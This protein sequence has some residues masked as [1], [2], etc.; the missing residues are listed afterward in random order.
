MDLNA[1]PLNRALFA[2][3]GL[4]TIFNRNRAKQ[5][6]PLTL[7]A[8]QR[9]GFVLLGER[10]DDEVVFGLIAR[11]WLALAGIRRTEAS[12][13]K[14]F[15]TPGF[16]KIAWNFKLAREASNVVA[17]STETRILCTDAASRTRFRWY[18]TIVRPF[19]GLTRSEMLR[20]VRACAEKGLLRH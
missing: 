8:I 12:E 14:A 6:E 16:A 20:L 5:R 13:F 18:W 15:S 19:S 11:P 1:S 9:G 2:L 7:A 3:R 4:P 17:L 10:A